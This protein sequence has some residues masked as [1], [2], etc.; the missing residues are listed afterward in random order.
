MNLTER[1][2]ATNRKGLLPRPARDCC[3]Q[4][5]GPALS[6]RLAI[7]GRP[8]LRSADPGRVGIADVPGVVSRTRHGATPT[9]VVSRLVLALG[10]LVAS[11]GLARGQS[12]DSEGVLDTPNRSGVL[13]TISLDGN[14]LD[15]SAPFFQALGTNGRSCGSCH[16]PASAWTI[17]PSELR[18]RF[19]ATDGLDPIFRTNDGSDSPA[20]DVSTTHARRRAYGMLLRKGLIR[21]GLP[22][23]GEAE[24]ELAGVDDPYHYASASELS[25]FRRPLPSTNLR[26]LTAVMWD[27]RESFAPGGTVPISPGATPDQNAEALV[28]DLGHQA[29]D[30]NLGHAEAAGPLPAAE[31]DAIV[32]FELNL[33][34]AQQVDHRAGDLTARGAQGGPIQVARQEFYVTINDVLGG[35][36]STHQFDPSAMTLYDAWRGGRHGH[37]AAIA[38]GAVIFNTRGFEIRGVGGLNDDLGLPAIS[39]TCTTCHDAPNIGNHSVP[40]PID[41]GLTD[42]SRRT[43][44]LPLYTLRNKLT[45]EIRQSTDP[46]RALITGRWKDIGK[47]KGPVLRGLAARPPYFHNGSAADLGAVVDFYDSRFSIGLTGRERADLVAFLTAL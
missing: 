1:R 29:D 24:F 44:D 8:R 2:R 41:I 37:R 43:P 14:A 25:L 21:I 35:D 27:G 3:R 30:A 9:Q 28:A 31:R 42:A 6:R 34:T 12:I 11:R 39:G 5:L 18:A 46:G 15:P 40:L 33:A 4:R 7:R 10:S 17:T 22:I 26:F 47:F 36:V 19:E 38:R 13:R 32:R 20:A 16:V 23:P 45:G